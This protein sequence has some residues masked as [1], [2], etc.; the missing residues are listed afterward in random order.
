MITFR[1]ADRADQPPSAPEPSVIT[2]FAPTGIGEVLP[3]TDLGAVILA[4]IEADRMGPLQ[5]GD[6]VVVTSKIISKAEGRE[7]PASRRAELI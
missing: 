1:G 2:I 3:G 7:E 6:V 5:D 4:S